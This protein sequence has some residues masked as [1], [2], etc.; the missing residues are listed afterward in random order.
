[1]T[2]VDTDRL[3]YTG[4][5]PFL[6]LHLAPM[7]VLWVG[8]SPLALAACLVSYCVRMFGITGGY[9]RYFAHRSY[10]TSRAFQF[11]LAL[12]GATAAQNGPLWWASHH[13]HHHRHSDTERDFHSP[14]R[15]GF[16]WSHTIWFLTYRSARTDYNSVK[17]LARYP[18]LHFFNRYPFFMAY[19]C[20]GAWMT[21][22]IWVET[23]LPGLGTNRW[24]MLVWGF[25]VSTLLLYHGTFTI[26]SL[27]HLYGSRRYNTRDDSKNNFWLALITLG[28][29]WHNNH[30]RYPGSERQGFYWW[31]I[32]LTHS[33]LRCLEK[34][35]LVWDLRAPPEAVL[36]EGLS[37]EP[38]PARR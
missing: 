8:W 30:H 34:L 19:V 1:M 12:L 7:A 11:F 20:A 31:E 3:D 29:G 35:G 15:T 14:R 18:E 21:L 36:E 13:R 25:F 10:R 32:D 23:A 2:E 24:Q 26:N 27:S 6:F 17:D 33:I 37:R 5:I 38:E 28:E 16:W 9:H 22:G 4:A